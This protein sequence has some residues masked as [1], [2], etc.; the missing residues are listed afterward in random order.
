[1]SANKLHQLIDSHPKNS[2]ALTLVGGGSSSYGDLVL[3]SKQIATG[4]QADGFASGDRMLILAELNANTLACIIALLRI[5]G[6]PVVA[7]PGSGRDVLQA[8][9]D[10]SAAKWILISSKLYLIR[11]HP[12]LQRLIRGRR[13]DLPH[14]FRV[15]LPKNVVLAPSR[16]LKS[17]PTVRKYLKSDAADLKEKDHD[18]ALIVFTS[19][20]TDSPKGVMHTHR[21]LLASIQIVK[22]LINHPKPILYTH[23]P[24]F[25]LLGIVVGAQVVL[26]NH[27]F[28]AQRFIANADIHKPTLTFGPPGEFIPVINYIR[29]GAARFPASY[30]QVMFGSAP[31]TQSFLRKFKAICGS[32]S[33]TCLYGMTEALPISSVDMDEKIAFKG[34]GDLLGSPAGDIQVRIV[35]GELLVKGPQVA[36]SYLN[37]KNQ[38]WIH[39]GDLVTLEKKAIVLKGRKKD[40][41]LRR[42]YNIYP[43]LYESTIT[44]IKGIQACALIG[45]YNAGAEDERI[46]LVVEPDGSVK[47]T[48]PDIDRQ[49]KQGKHSIDSN[50][51]PDKIVI[52]QLPRTG[53]QLKIDKEALRESFR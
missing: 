14:L 12:L 48:I 5:G 32:V 19:G 3:K 38:V 28:N 47:L 21:S 26:D 1:M 29:G 37:K 17:R 16:V 50:A 41:I 7:D 40:M 49:L 20:T 46:I 33:A 23:Q 27:V 6:V 45:V 44:G 36:P 9:I 2:R 8:R 34:D 15:R 51:L 18:E 4:L 52:A 35:D 53:R 11:N 13:K 42:S 22:G 43:S 31:I 10:E 24:Y 30:K 39:T 25:A